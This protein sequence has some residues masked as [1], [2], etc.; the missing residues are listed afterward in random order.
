MKLT[1][2]VKKRYAR[3]VTE[4]IAFSVGVGEV[5][6]QTEKLCDGGRP[7]MSKGHSQKAKEAERGARSAPFAKL[8]GLTDTPLQRKVFFQ[9]D[10][11]LKK[12]SAFTLPLPMQR[13]D[14]YD[15]N[16]NGDGLFLTNDTG[17]KTCEKIR[18]L[19]ASAGVE[20]QFL[21]V[22]HIYFSA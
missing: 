2:M 4:C 15:G 10:G 18:R 21:H 12:G 9:K 8:F 22:G 1:E 19:K 20:Q 5:S 17:S 11:K 7:T 3:D 14:V 6:R 13:Y 16:A